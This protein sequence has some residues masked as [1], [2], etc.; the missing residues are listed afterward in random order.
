M[1]FF[2]VLKLTFNTSNFDRRPS[3]TINLK[4][5]LKK[6]YIYTFLVLFFQSD[7]FGNDRLK[8]SSTSREN[9]IKKRNDVI[10]EKS[11]AAR[12]Q[13]DAAMTRFARGESPT[14]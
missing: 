14:H 13:K 4:V 6:I 5:V 3:V 9:Y 12:P 10:W 2:L 11:G 7:I 8:G 1:K